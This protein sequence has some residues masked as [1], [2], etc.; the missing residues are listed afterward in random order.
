MRISARKRRGATPPVGTELSCHGADY[1][2]LRCD[3]QRVPVVDRR[4]LVAVEAQ[5]AGAPVHVTD[6]GLPVGT[7]EA[8]T[9]IS[10][11]LIDPLGAYSARIEVEAEVVRLWPTGLSTEEGGLAEGGQPSQGTCR[12]D[13]GT[14]TLCDGAADRRVV[15]VSGASRRISSTVAIPA[16]STSGASIGLGA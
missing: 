15:T 6:D 10:R 9:G 11:Q 1:D 7:L 8:C 5:V 4:A 13:E 2:R 3:R 14:Q 12:C 16:P